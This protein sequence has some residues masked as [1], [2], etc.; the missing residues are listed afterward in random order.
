M[1]YKKQLKHVDF[2]WDSETKTLTISKNEEFFETGKWTTL[3]L[4]KSE[5]GSLQ[6][7]IFSMIQ[8]HANASKSKKVATKQEK[9]QEDVSEELESE[10]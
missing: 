9:S 8:F 6:R 2:F 1:V 5:M 3:E 10:E 7:F 4:T